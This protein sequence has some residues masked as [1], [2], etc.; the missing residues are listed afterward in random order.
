MA[1]QY[2]NPFGGYAQGYGSGVDIA[3]RL[4]SG[5]RQAREADWEHQYMDPLRLHGAQ[6]TDTYNTKALPYQLDAANSGDISLRSRA[7]RDQLDAA[8]QLATDT[9]DTNA[10][11]YAGHNFDPQGYYDQPSA[12]LQ[13]RADFPRNIQL[14]TLGINDYY[15]TML[16]QGALLRGDAAVTRADETGGVANYTPPSA[17]YFS[18]TP[19]SAPAAAPAPTPSPAAAPTVPAFS[20]LH[21]VAQGHVIHH[22]ATALGVT[23]EQAA[24]HI[25]GTT[26]LAPGVTPKAAPAPAPAV[27]S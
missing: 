10:L 12:E 7:L 27:A 3:Q 18:S 25:T 23:P 19:A 5:A 26:P 11:N 9:G 15:R 2:V 13:N 1:E 17:R 16:G 24:G 21:P 8:G 22:V 14:G 6:L 4:Q 20:A